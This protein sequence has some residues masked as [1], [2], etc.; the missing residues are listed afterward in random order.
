MDQLHQIGAERISILVQKS[1]GVVKHDSGE[2]IETERGLQIGTR[3]HV[4]PVAAVSL[5]Q[6]G[7]HGLVRALEKNT[8]YIKP[9]NNERQLFE[10]NRL[11]IPLGI[12]ILHR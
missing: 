12:W 2:M 5:V 6:L 8:N 4:V 3:F 10:I 1:S 7:Q 9:I 11:V